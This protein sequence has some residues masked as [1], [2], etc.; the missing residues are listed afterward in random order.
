MAALNMNSGFAGQTVHSLRLHQGLLKET[1]LVKT[2]SIPKMATLAKLSKM[3]AL[4]MIYSG[5]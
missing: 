1:V 2:G 4:R 3:D 5:K